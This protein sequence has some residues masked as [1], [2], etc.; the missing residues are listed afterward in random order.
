MRCFISYSRANSGP[1]DALAKRLEGDGHDVWIDRVGIEGGT[2]WR[3]KIVVAIEEADVF[4]LILSHKSVQSSNVRKEVDLAES[5][6]KKIVPILIE[7]VTLPSEL[8]YQLSGVQMIDM[9]DLSASSFALLQKALGVSVAESIDKPKRAS[10][11]ISHSGGG[12]WIDR[13]MK[14]KFFG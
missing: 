13:V 10:V 2:E 5:S 8:R 14:R 3:T 11:D 12:G 4:L 9:P 7:P 1:V 6:N